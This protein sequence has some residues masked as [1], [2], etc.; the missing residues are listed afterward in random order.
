M[1]N[2]IVMPIHLAARY[3][4]DPTYDPF[5]DMRPREVIICRRLMEQRARQETALVK[6]NNREIDNS[7]D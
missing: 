5:V 7:K 3:M 6:W 1:T 4:R 2:Y